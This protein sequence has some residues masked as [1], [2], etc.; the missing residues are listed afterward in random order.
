MFSIT[1]SP[2]RALAVVFLLVVAGRT[3]EAAIV[4]RN[5]S[6]PAGSHIRIR[7]DLVLEIDTDTPVASAVARIPGIQPGRA[8][9]L[10]AAC[11]PTSGTARCERRR[12]ELEILAQAPPE[13]PYDA[14][15]EVTNQAGESA[16]LTVPF[17]YDRPPI[18][19]M[20]SPPHGLVPRTR[21]VTVRGTCTDT[22][23]GG[24]CPIVNVYRTDDV[25]SGETPI[26]T[27]NNVTNVE[28]D[29]DLQ[30]LNGRG[31]S[32]HL[33]GLDGHPLVNPPTSEFT[34]ARSI[35]VDNT[36]AYRRI[37]EAPE[38]IVTDANS[39]RAVFEY[40]GWFE[41]EHATGTIE[42]LGG[43]G[44]VTS[45]GVAWRVDRTLYVRS[46]GVVQ[47]YPIG[48][49]AYRAA[50]RFLA[51]DTAQYG[52][53]SAAVHL[54]DVE[55]GQHT[56]IDASSGAVPSSDGSVY[57]VRRGS[58]SQVVYRDA[59]GGESVVA[60]GR[61]VIAADGPYALLLGGVDHCVPELY[62]PAGLIE[63]M[64]EATC[65]PS[66]RD[67]QAV[68]RNGWVA[69][70][71]PGRGVFRRS[72]DGVRTRIADNLGF[73]E[74]LS[75][76]GEL[77]YVLRGYEVNLSNRGRWIVPVT[78]AATRIGSSLG[79][80]AWRDGR[81]ILR[82][83]SSTF[84]IMA[85][86]TPEPTP[87]AGVP[88][89][90]VPD[91][92][93][94]DAGMDAPVDAGVDAPVDSG[95]DA[96]VDAGVDAAVDAGVDAP[97]DAGVDAAVDAAADAVVDAAAEVP[98]DAGVDAASPPDAGGAVPQLDAGADEPDDDRGCSA[99]GTPGV[100]IMLALAALR[101]RRRPRAG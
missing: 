1:S 97:V 55:S 43:L 23:S 17:V 48:S 76:D 8:M 75:P 70:S 13:G 53:P 74:D 45:R 98:A 40:G 37:G 30:R 10:L 47:S 32:L 7:F 87:D 26:A 88:D 28:V 34:Q 42:P 78:G 2:V 19:T 69:Y 56:V 100:L 6:T 44:V 94:P 79:D 21:Y 46:N 51:W 33:T 59:A 14:I 99:G 49:G 38:G 80:A 57:M 24:P 31:L 92:G 36:A 60:T 66:D 83:G 29:V 11:V 65:G 63:R 20:T 71:F 41:I 68:L 54:L 15:V 91:A 86:S 77:S 73:V 62:G 93:V 90:G 72:P 3:A 12:V 35:Y 82:M 9:W 5:T 67:Y 84:Q 81:W 16:T 52:A 4:L 18:V 25:A 85:P 50:G 95:V 61:Y 58:P 89:A 101:R 96:A 64:P 27:L 39:E 22:L